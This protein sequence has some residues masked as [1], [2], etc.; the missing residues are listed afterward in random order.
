MSWNSGPMGDFDGPTVREARQEEEKAAR[1][2]GEMTPLHRRVSDVLD[3]YLMR[4]HGISTSHTHPDLL[5]DL[6][7]AEGI[8][9]HTYHPE[10]V[11]L[12]KTTEV[13]EP[14]F[15]P[16]EAPMVEIDDDFYVHGDTV[17]CRMEHTQE[18]GNI[19]GKMPEGDE[20][21]QKMLTRHD[22][23]YHDGPGEEK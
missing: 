1:T 6:L 10:P 15:P 16:L 9:I 17:M 2:R 12:K 4:I 3:D 8:G 11:K 19:L 13:V 14:S 20:E 18:N 7:L 5:I 21:L 23:S 22:A